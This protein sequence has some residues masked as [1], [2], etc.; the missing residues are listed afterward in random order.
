MIPFFINNNPVT[1][2]VHQFSNIRIPGANHTTPKQIFH[3]YGESES[4]LYQARALDLDV[5]KNLLANVPTSKCDLARFNHM[6]ASIIA[7][8]AIGSGLDMIE[9]DGKKTS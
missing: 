2:L 8:E 5:N 7:S 3:R 4:L 1:Q 6:G 9:E